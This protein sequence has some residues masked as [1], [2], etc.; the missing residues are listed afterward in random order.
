VSAHDVFLT[1]SLRWC[2]LGTGHESPFAGREAVEVLFLALHFQSLRS[3]SSGNCLML[4][5]GQ[6]RVLIDCGFASQASCEK[7]LRQAA[8]DLSA[9][10]AVILSHA[11]SDHI[12]YSALRV[13][14]RHRVPIRLHEHCL[15]TL[16]SRHSLCDGFDGLRIEPF[17]DEAF[18]VGDLVFQP[19]QVPHHPGLATHG[20][21][22]RPVGSAQKIVVMTDFFDWRGLV[23]QFTDAHFVYVEANHD[24]GL[25]RQYPNFNSHYHLNNEKTGAL[26]YHAR[27]ESRSAPRA[28]MLGH[29]SEQRNTP[30]LALDAIHDAFG[31]NGARPDFELFVAPRYE[32][33]P[34]ITVAD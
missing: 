11:H 30:E 20:F 24:C 6:T 5:T 29:L 7:S 3:G 22:V 4:W 2:T 8:G 27:R 19:V 16:D 18:R 28:V 21:V 34:P 17:P 9:I 12:S 33:S 14:Q 15:A 31:M 26:L 25:L 10:D 1:T 23:E 13:L 32:P